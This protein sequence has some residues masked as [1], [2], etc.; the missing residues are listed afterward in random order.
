MPDRK[1]GR[2]FAKRLTEVTIQGERRGVAC[3]KVQVIQEL[4]WA[5]GERPS[6]SAMERRLDETYCDVMKRAT[7]LLKMCRGPGDNSGS[8]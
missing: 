4:Q 2:K 6:I 7:L 1:K 8:D 5:M 3:M